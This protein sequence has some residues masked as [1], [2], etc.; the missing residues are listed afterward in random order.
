MKKALVLGTMVLLVVL[1]SPLAAEDDWPQW[2][3]PEATGRSP[4][5]DPPTEWSEEKNIRWKV[6]VPG[7][8]HAAPIVWKDH[9]YVLTAV[10]VDAA[11]AAAAIPPPFDREAARARREAAQRQR[12]EGGETP[13]EG[14]PPEGRPPQGG[15]GR[16]PRGRRGGF[17]RGVQPTAHRFVVQARSRADGSVVWERT[18]IELQPAEGTHRDGTWASASPVTDGEVLVAQFGSPGLFV[19]DLAGELLW[20]KNLGDMQTRNS[21]GEGS[22]PAIHGDTVVVNWD[23]E[24]ESFIV[25]LDKATG[26]ERWRVAR[27]EPTSWSTPVVLEVGGKPQ[28]VVAA[29]GA[30]RGYD[31]ASGETIWQLGGLTLNVVPSPVYGDGLVYLMSGFRGNALQA[32]RIEGARGDLAGS[33]AV[34][35]THDRHTPYVPSPLLYG[36]KLYFLKSNTAILSCLD[37]KTGE[38]L[39]TE[40]RIEG[41]DNV[42]A[43]IVGAAGRVYVT[44]R[45]GTTVVLRHG[46]DYEVLASNTLDEAFDA[47]PAIAGGEIYLR[48]KS[49]LYSLAEAP[50]AAGA[51]GR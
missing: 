49:Y 35:W 28:V 30:S 34:A 4:T 8:G 43:S 41:L 6:E 40:Q 45:G 9:V 29:S 18:A 1:A 3:G 2:R 37:A 47:S 24:G 46:A 7:R 11:A 27:D 26:K 16:P 48:G 17:M 36:D 32:V 12:A 23:H 5:G 25:A 33:A 42:Y 19:Y 51:G 21:F 38:V 22:S 50:A 39:Y 31:L 15:E 10:P 20:Q 13:P 44:G 14:R